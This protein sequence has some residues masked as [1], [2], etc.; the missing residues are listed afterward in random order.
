[1]RLEKGLGRDN[2]VPKQA[3]GQPSELPEGGHS[4][5]IVL[6]GGARINAPG[7]RPDF[8]RLDDVLS[9]SIFSR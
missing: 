3:A 6:I 7:E 9:G 5:S 1:V 4:M 8:S 2:R